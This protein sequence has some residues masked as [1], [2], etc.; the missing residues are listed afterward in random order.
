MLSIAVLRYEPFQRRAGLW[1]NPAVDIQ[2]PAGLALWS[3]RRRDGRATYRH[4]DYDSVLDGV[5]DALT[6]ITRVKLLS[7]ITDE[8]GRVI[9]PQFCE[10]TPLNSDAPASK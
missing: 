8:D 7:K 1:A 9:I 5:Y 10:S 6:V 4:V 3:R 2:R